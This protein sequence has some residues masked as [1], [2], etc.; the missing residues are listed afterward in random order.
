MGAKIK[1]ILLLLFVLSSLTACHTLTSTPDSGHDKKVTAAGLNIQLGMA[2][3]ERHEVQRAKQKFLKALREAPQLPEVWYS[4][5][6]YF[7]VTGDKPRATRCYLRA[8]ELAPKRGDTN[9][10][11]GTFLC[12]SHHYKDAIKHFLIAT[13]DVEYLDTA[14]AYENAGLCAE[15]VPAPRAAISYFESALKQD[16]NRSMSLLGLAEVNYEL[17]NY[18]QAANYL[19]QYAMVAQPTPESQTLRAKLE[20]KGFSS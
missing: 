18:E 5:A 19:K 14:S 16:P 3:L 9:N 12:R 2:Y 7:E 1:N 13:Q 6:Y 17:K 10:N 11:Y 4:L 8:L 20:R 15:L